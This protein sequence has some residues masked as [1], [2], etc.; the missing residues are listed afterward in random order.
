MSY[1]VVCN[2]SFYPL[3]L[4]WGELVLTFVSFTVL[5]LGA[6]LSRFNAFSGKGVV[7]GWKMV[8]IYN[9]SI[10]VGGIL[11]IFATQAAA[12]IADVMSWIVG[13]PAVTVIAMELLFWLIKA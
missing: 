1:L 12:I 10:I 11:V 6:V 2:Q 3:V 5:I 13:I 7:Y 9:I 4:W 8:G